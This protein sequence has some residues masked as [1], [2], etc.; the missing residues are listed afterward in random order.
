LHDF[1]AVRPLVHSFHGLARVARF[2]LDCRVV[3]AT[4][5]AALERA[6]AGCVVLFYCVHGGPI[7]LLKSAEAAYRAAARAGVRRL[8]YLSSTVVYG[9]APPIGTHDDSELLAEQAFEYNVA[10]VRAEQKLRELRAD[11]A[12]EVVT[13][14]PAIVFGPRSTWFSANIAQ[15]LLGGRAFLV[16]DGAGVCN[17]VYV[18]NLIEAMWLAAN[19]NGVVNQDFII[20]D[21]ERVTW[22]DLYWSVAKA[23]N[24]DMGAVFLTN[25]AAA[26]KGGWPYRRLAFTL[27][28][29]LPPGLKWA[30]RVLL[31]GRFIAGAVKALQPPVL[32]PYLV[33]TQH[34]R[35]VLPISK[36]RDVLGYRPRVS[37]AEGAR[38]T[39][40]WLRFALG[41]GE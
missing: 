1:A 22:R 5:A 34:C 27:L 4:D 17:T 13:L 39:G 18:D 15:D 9:N 14:R 29:R 12:V 24:A 25:F 6:L 30:L 37:F 19:S 28:S 2:D 26:G 7:T 38:R 40:T 32:D 23:V 8:V 20:T 36:A 10:K 11:G 3:D 31:P 16:D 33:T 41:I 21:G 35:C